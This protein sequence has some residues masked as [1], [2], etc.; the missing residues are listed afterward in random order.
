MATVS[1]VI[2]D[3]IVAGDGYYDTDPRVVRIVEYTDM[4]GKLAYGIE[5]PGELGKYGEASVYIR[6]P[7]MYWAQPDED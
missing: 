7:K 3:K 6:A 2:A 5:Y 4:G 1:K